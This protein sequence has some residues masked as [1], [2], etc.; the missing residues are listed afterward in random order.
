MENVVLVNTK[1]EVLGEMEKMEVHRKGLLHRAFSVFVFNSSN[2][3]LMQKRASS[4]YHSGGLW[5]NTC[6]SHPR[7]NETI[8]DAGKRRL[9]EEMGFSTELTE[10]FSFIY[11]ADLDN[12]LIEYEYDFVLIGKFE[13]NPVIN[14][15]E[16]ED[17]AYWNM[18]FIELDMEQNPKKYTEWF[19]ICFP[20]L[21]EMLNLKAA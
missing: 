1:N 2:E 9:Q 21:K 16:V 3:L 13:D 17:F 12:Q 19:K 11:K 7:L 4:K 14:L 20:K 10:M 15:D 6:C 18:D 8:L 5:T